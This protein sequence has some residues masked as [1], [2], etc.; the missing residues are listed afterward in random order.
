MLLTPVVIKVAPINNNYFFRGFLNV[1]LLTIRVNPKIDPIVE[2]SVPKTFLFLLPEL[3][4]SNEL[5]YKLT[6]AKYG[7]LKRKI[8][9]CATKERI[10]ILC[11]CL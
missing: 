11:F 3:P 7:R 8:I 6:K 1:L 4:R 9:L 2:K 5:G 10:I